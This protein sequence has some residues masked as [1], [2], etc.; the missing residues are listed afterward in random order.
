MKFFDTKNIFKSRKII[1]LSK[2]YYIYAGFILAIATISSLYSAVRLYNS[3][4][5]S[6][7]NQLISGSQLIDTQLGNYFNYVSHIAEDKGY[8]ISLKK[9]DI[10]HIDHLFKRSFFFPVTAHGLKKKAFIWPHMSWIDKNGNILVKSEIG[11]LPKPQKAE[12]SQELYL[13]SKDHWQMHLSN[14]YYDP[15]QRKTLINAFLGV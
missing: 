4:K 10:K 11:I 14:P 1:S 2:D 12:E 7:T 9:G 13:S 8:K 15:I 3:Q 6:L 5:L